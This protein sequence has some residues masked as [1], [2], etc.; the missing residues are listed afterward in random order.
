MAWPYPHSTSLTERGRVQYLILFLSAR[1]LCSLLPFKGEEGRRMRLSV[2]KMM[3][4]R[5]GLMPLAPF[6]LVFFCIRSCRLRH[7]TLR[8]L[9]GSIAHPR[10]PY[11]SRR[12]V[13]FS[14]GFI[15]Y[16]YFYFIL[17]LFV[18]S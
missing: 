13:L 3:A 1:Y 18:S 10:R 2:H 6:A 7:S 12:A 16:G 14:F 4:Y 9:R 17:V 5:V 8:G 11:F 15:S